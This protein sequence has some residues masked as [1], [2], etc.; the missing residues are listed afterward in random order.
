MGDGDSERQMGPNGTG[1]WPGPFL[2]VSSRSLSSQAPTGAL[3]NFSLVRILRPPCTDFTRSTPCLRP[4]NYQ[5][6]DQK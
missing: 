1:F 6:A 3:L 4:S 5:T 2:C